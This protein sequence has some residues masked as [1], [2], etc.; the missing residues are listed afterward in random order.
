L[1]R[2][3][4]AA[5][6]VYPAGGATGQLLETLLEREGVRSLSIPVELTLLLGFVE[7]LPG[8]RNHDESDSDKREAENVERSGMRIRPS[9]ERYLQKVFA[10]VGEPIDI[11]IITLRP[12]RG[13][14]DGE[15]K[16][17]RFPQ[18]MRLESR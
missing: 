7:G 1:K 9:A 12:S 14:V 3:G 5:T 6:A 2:L 15:R 17:V 4:I 16:S 8:H 10:V 11:G 18:T 13:E